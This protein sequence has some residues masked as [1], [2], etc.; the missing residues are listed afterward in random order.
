MATGGDPG[1][2][3]RGPSSNPG[4]P[5]SPALQWVPRDRGSPPFPASRPRLPTL[6][7]MIRS[8]G[9]GP[10]AGA[11]GSPCPSPRPG[12][13]RLPL[14]PVCSR[15]RLAAEARAASV[16]VPSSFVLPWLGWHVEF[17]PDPRAGRSSG[18]TCVWSTRT[19]WV[20]PTHFMRFLPIP[21]FR[22]YLGATKTPFGLL[23]NKNA[24]L[25]VWAQ[26]NPLTPKA[27]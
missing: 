1:V 14:C 23:T 19:H 24:A 20:T 17:P 13:A 12:G 3:P 15:P 4:G 11:C 25:L 8:D 7:T 6:G 21:R 2:S 5:A 26:T 10:I 9:Q 27:A 18:G 22:V 16:L